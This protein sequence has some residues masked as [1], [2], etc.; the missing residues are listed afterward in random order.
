MAYNQ[1]FDEMR[2][3]QIFHSIGVIGKYF[4]ALELR[5]PSMAGWNAHYCSFFI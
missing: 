1:W 5:A 4:K 2:C 3:S